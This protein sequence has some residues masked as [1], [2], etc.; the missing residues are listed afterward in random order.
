MD[1]QRLLDTFLELVQVDS[2]SLH[3]AAVAQ[4]C[5][6]AFEEAG[7]TV[8]IDG[9]AA[10]TG[11]D[12][13][14]LTAT[15]AGTAPGCLYFSAHM[16]TVSPGIGVRPVIS[17]GIIRSLGETVLGGDDK[18]GVAAIIE[19]VRTLAEHDLPHPRVVV[20]LSVGEEIDLLGAK[21]MDGAAF[22]GEPCFVLDAAGHP[23]IV[24]IGAPYHH[25]FTATFTGQAAHAG[26]APETGVSAIGMAAHAIA[27]ME[28]GRLDAQTTANI[29]T[30]AGGVA[31]NIIA[32]TCTV[33]GECRSQTPE[34]VEEVHAHIDACLRAAAAD[35][36]AVA[37]GT[38]AGNGAVGVEVA[39]AENYRGFKLPQDDP[40]A[41]LA[42]EAAHAL[43]LP[44][45]TEVTGGGADTNVLNEKGLHA[46][47]LGT[48][49]TAIHGC[50][51]QLAVGDLESL[52]R[53]VIEITY[54]YNGE[55][56]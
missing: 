12:T 18:C 42:L 43:G 13:G 48:G 26:V 7:C 10:V 37:A 52:A 1:A 28:L 19:L 44:A 8:S 56:R 14:N 29:G 47:T 32:A 4:Y 46:V 53:L 38:A 17:D 2:P 25:S 34:R 15:L 5:K 9:T 40:V 11:S 55:E 23:G 22:D 27:A 54:R 41:V 36:A 39:W 50:H 6:R 31:N 20:L 3:E 45:G 33:T 35:A 16:D 49:M 21:A 24:V 30:V 51:E